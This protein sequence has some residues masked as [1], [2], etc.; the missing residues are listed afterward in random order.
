MSQRK[1]GRACAVGLLAAALLVAGSAPASAAER[2]SGSL[3]GWM[4]KGWQEWTGTV[5]VPWR[6]VE[7]PRSGERTWIKEGPGI[8]PNGGT[9]P[10]PGST[11][12]T[13]CQDCA[14]ATG[15]GL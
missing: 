13:A 10:K 9:A 14:P 7:T 12:G 11:A 2:G 1:I 8:D 4:V 3:W 5:F 6:S 15:G